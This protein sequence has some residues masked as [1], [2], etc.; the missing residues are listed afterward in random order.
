VILTDRPPFRAL[1]GAGQLGIRPSPRLRVGRRS[2]GAH[3]CGEL[4]QIDLDR[5]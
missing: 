4:V 3:P 1:G 5:R 2:L